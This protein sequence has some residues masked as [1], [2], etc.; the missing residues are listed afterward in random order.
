MVSKTSVDRYF[1]PSLSKAETKADITNRTARAITDAAT[2]LRDA[3]TAK[4]RQARLAQEAEQDAAALTSRKL[5]RKSARK[6]R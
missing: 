2:A 6:K 5:P 1:K 3:K 4:L